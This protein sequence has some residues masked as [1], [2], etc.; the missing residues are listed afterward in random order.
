M[1]I[2]HIV[3]LATATS[4][5]AAC[6]PEPGGFSTSPPQVGGD[7]TAF[8][9]AEAV[10]VR[11]YDTSKSEMEPFVT[12]DGAYL[13]FNNAND[14]SVD[15]N[16]Q[17][18]RRVDDVT[19]DYLGELVGAD[20]AALDGVPTVARDGQ[21]YFVSTRSYDATL[22]TIY[23]AQL[24]T[25][26]ATAAA[27]ALVPGV[28]RDEPLAVNF[29]V[30]ISADGRTMYFVDAGMS[31]AGVPQHADIVID[32][33]AADGSFARRADSDALMANVDSTSLEYAPAISEDELELFFTRLASIADAADSPPTIYRAARTSVDEPFGIPQHVVAAAGFVEGPTLGPGGASLYYHHCDGDTCAI[34]RIA[35]DRSP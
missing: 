26:A 27:P 12:R 15:T 8:G 10:T 32:E 29:D 20:S 18:A 13:L 28:A 1:G 24:D 7:Y 21:L 19:F 9:S 34:F 23:S 35:R 3:A 31:R 25:T 16:L 6:I 17:I 4:L 14:P 22:S 2:S 30:E 5:T 33:R 11:G